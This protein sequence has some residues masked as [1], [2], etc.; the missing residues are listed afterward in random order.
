MG[1]SE[2]TAERLSGK[3][4]AGEFY[5]SGYK[6]RTAGRALMARAA[7]RTEE[8]DDPEALLAALLKKGDGS[9]AR[10]DRGKPVEVRDYLNDLA[11]E[12]AIK[13]IIEFVSMD[14]SSS[15]FPDEQQAIAGTFRLFT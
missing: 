4:L 3:E 5:R 14:E 8:F 11:G 6:D 13:G 10:T 1:I 15:D 9:L 12:A 2:A 7:E